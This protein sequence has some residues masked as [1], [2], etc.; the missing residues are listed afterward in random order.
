MDRK[1]VGFVTMQLKTKRSKA[2]GENTMARRE[3]DKKNQ[4]KRFYTDK[5]VEVVPIGGGKGK[6]NYF[7]EVVLSQHAKFYAIKKSELEIMICI[8]FKGGKVEKYHYFSTERTS[9]FS[10][11]YRIKD[12]ETIA[13]RKS[14]LAGEV[15]NWLV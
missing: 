10:R 4:E 15:Q 13:F 5:L 12:G 6:Y 8:K 9:T 2:K 14:E 3:E 7:I 1:S 11:R